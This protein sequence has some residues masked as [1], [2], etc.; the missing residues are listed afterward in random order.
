MAYGNKMERI[1]ADAEQILN[2]KA[3]HD[4]VCAHCSTHPVIL[5]ILWTHRTPSSPLPQYLPLPNGEPT[6]EA[7]VESLKRKGRI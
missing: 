1:R 2:D 7:I 3:L 6:L 4:R 5:H